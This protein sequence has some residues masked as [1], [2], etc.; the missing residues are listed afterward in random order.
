MAVV[1]SWA[2]QSSDGRCPNAG[3]AV[4][5][6]CSDKVTDW[7]VPHSFQFFIICPKT[8]STFKIEVDALSCS[9]N[10]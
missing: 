6:L 7:W 4:G 9:K 10:S 2:R 1:K 3:G 8:G 5:C